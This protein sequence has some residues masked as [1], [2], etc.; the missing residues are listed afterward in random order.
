MAACTKAGIVPPDDWER[1]CLSI[2]VDARVK[3]LVELAL[4]FV[5]TIPAELVTEVGRLPQLDVCLR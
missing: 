1:G 3:L 4:V 2:V 5:E